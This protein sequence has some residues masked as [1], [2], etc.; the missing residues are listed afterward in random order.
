MVRATD[1]EPETL[2]RAIKAGNH[3]ASSGVSLRDVRFDP[4]KKQLQVDIETKPGVT[5]TTEFIG[6]EHRLRREIGSRESTRTAN[7]FARRGSIRTMSAGR[8]GHG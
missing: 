6:T 4:A 2:V 5:Y 3:Y 1:L 7:R 8:S